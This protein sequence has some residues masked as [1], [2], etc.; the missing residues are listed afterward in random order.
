MLLSLL[1][2]RVRSF[3]WT[4]LNPLTSRLFCDKF[5]W[6]WLS[7][8]GEEDLKMILFKMSSM[9]F[10][11]IISPLKGSGPSFAK[12]KPTWI[13]FTQRCSAPSLFKIHWV[14][15]EKMKIRKVYRGQQTTANQKSSP[16]LSN[17]SQN[18]EWFQQ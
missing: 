15:L 17:I 18:S 8:S 10:F 6:N 13:N 4:N 1:E 9:Y 5:G 11:A 12:K 14:I 2:K 3:I 16:K 7:G